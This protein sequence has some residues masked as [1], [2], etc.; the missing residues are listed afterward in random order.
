MMRKAT[1]AVVIA[2]VALFALGSAACGSEVDAGSKAAIEQSKKD[3]EAEIAQQAVEA[4]RARGLELVAEGSAVIEEMQALGQEAQAKLMAG[5]PSG[6]AVV[7]EIGA[8][9]TELE[10]IVD[11][12]QTLDVP[13]TE[14]GLAKLTRHT[15]DMRSNFGTVEAGCA[16]VGY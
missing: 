14:D 13:G 3:G 5:D 7:P 4:D 16:Q 1:L 15:S 9:V 8:K 6:C 12:L 10:G 11:E 2:L